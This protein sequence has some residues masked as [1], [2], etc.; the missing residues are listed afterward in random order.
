MIIRSYTDS[1]LSRIKELHAQSKFDY[2]LPTLS[3]ESFFSLRVIEGD[4]N[5]QMAA[6]MRHTAEAY[7]IC[8]PAWRN[9]AWR[10][11]ALRQLSRVCN[12]D[13]RDVGVQEVN[14][15]LPPE[16]ESKFGKRLVRMG[17]TG[18][19]NDW[20]CFYKKVG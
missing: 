19:R 15:F 4:G 16:V 2:S 11:E 18:I 20:H 17:W 3:R 1:D 7:L 8:D 12:D 9:P 13:A 5:V 10:M 6:F 14:C